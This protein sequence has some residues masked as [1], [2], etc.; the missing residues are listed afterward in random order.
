MTEETIT[1]GD[2]V[3]AKMP[4]YPLW[5]A[6]VIYPVPQVTAPYI[7]DESQHFVKFYGPGTNLCSWIPDKH[8]VKHSPKLL[9]EGKNKKSKKLQSAIVELEKDLKSNGPIGEIQDEETYEKKRY[10]KRKRDQA[11]IKT[12]NKKTKV[13][14][15]KEINHTDVV[16]KDH[17]L[18]KN[19]K[20]I[21]KYH[22]MQEK[23]HAFDGLQMQNE[24]E[25]DKSHKIQ[26][27]VNEHPKLLPNKDCVTEN[28]M[29]ID[30]RC[31]QQL[32]IEQVIPIKGCV[33][34]KDSTSS[35]QSIDT[36]LKRLFSDEIL[37]NEFWK[38]KSGKKQALK[39]LQKIIEVLKDE[40]EKE[41]SLKI[42][43]CDMQL[44]YQEKEV[45][46]NPNLHQTDK[47]D[48]A[49]KM[50]KQQGEV[51]EHSK[52]LKK[53]DNGGENKV[54]CNPEMRANEQ[55]VLSTKDY[56]AGKKS[57]P[58]EHTTNKTVEPI[59]YSTE[60]LAGEF[61]ETAIPHAQ[62]TTSSENEFH[63]NVRNPIQPNDSDTLHLKSSQK[64]LNIIPH[65]LPSLIK[66]FGVPKDSNKNKDSLFRKKIISSARPLKFGF[67]GNGFLKNCILKKLI[68]SK[69][70]VTVWID[71][72]IEANEKAYYTSCAKTV[73]T[74]Q[75]L[76]ENCD[77]IFSYWENSETVKFQ[78]S[79]VLNSVS[80][81]DFSNKGYVELST[82]DSE[83]A[84][85]CGSSVTSYG[86]QFLEAA[87]LG[88]IQDAENGDLVLL[89]SGDQNLFDECSSP[90]RAISKFWHYF[91][92]EI[93]RG[94]I[95][96]VG[97]SML[98]GITHAGLA[99]VVALIRKNGFNED[100]FTDILN[101]TPFQHWMEKGKLMFRD[102]H[103]S[104]RPVN[105]QRKDFYFGLKLALRLKQPT[106]TCSAA[107]F[108]FE[109][110]HH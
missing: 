3:W 16:I 30:N 105:D 89:A 10:K 19:Q 41:E 64:S 86:G 8:I 39:H 32:E 71:T 98:Q 100:E 61:F 35:E 23:E 17:N 44:Q 96:K 88:D 73:K 108:F 69:F 109:R 34:E 107:N 68:L 90:F 60:V 51:I 49:Q 72:S 43:K 25:F 102:S 38:N 26:D 4:S 1:I 104:F 70:N 22:Q 33:T 63:E 81:D 82:L 85:N 56:I 21:D 87:I 79:Q 57:P 83:T 76:V 47:F 36:T 84:Y 59:I 92:G 18:Y 94:S 67:M 55:R 2:I 9:K 62:F 95:M 66:P 13:S 28:D 97:H 75:A 99:E 58:S 53:K 29:E 91:G 5:P 7:G 31:V 93:G 77:I 11:A 14:G 52:I 6:I 101:C 20:E 54:L 110:N 27:K 12:K 78:L 15:Y 103:I 48:E 106:W 46:K 65:V 45:N 40:I 80:I 50:L 74:F 37:L 42:Q 24:H